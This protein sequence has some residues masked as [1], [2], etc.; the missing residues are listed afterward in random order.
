MSEDLRG[1][2]EQY[3]VPPTEYVGDFDVPAN[4][5]PITQIEAAESLVP[6]EI[7]VSTPET[8]IAEVLP[9]TELEIIAAA[10]AG[11][12]RLRELYNE[13]FDLAA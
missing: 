7:S 8:P 12:M 3:Y 10:S 9:P 6:Q 13:S 1:S 4:E 2:V 5:R 11:V